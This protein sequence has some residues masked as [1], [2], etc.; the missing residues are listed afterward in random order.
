MLRSLVGSEMCIRD[1][2]HTVLTLHGAYEPKE[3][4]RRSQTS[5]RVFRIHFVD[6]AGSEL[7]TQKFGTQQQK[8]TISINLSLLSLRSTI[9]ALA[10]KESF[11]PY[12]SLIHI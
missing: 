5:A 3:V 4:K 8:E 9:C 6:L 2:A 12:L 7:L 1:S 10:A 11:I